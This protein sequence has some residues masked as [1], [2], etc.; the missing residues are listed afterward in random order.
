MA[1]KTPC[2]PSRNS[3]RPPKVF[4]KPSVLC[5]VP[6]HSERRPYTCGTRLVSPM[7]R[8]IED[9]EVLTAK[10][11]RGIQVYL[12]RADRYF[13]RVHLYGTPEG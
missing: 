13:D 2:R 4:R 6:E 11:G 10:M 5:D 1:G 3:S 8:R 12:V 9:A 7:L